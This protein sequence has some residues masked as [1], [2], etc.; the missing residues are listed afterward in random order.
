MKLAHIASAILVWSVFSV[1]PVSAQDAGTSQQQL[2]RLRADM[3]VMREDQRRLYSMLQENRQAMERLQR[4]M[5]EISRRLGDGGAA[6]SSEAA[7]RRDIEA[8]RRALR[9]ESEARQKAI[10]AVIDTLSRDIAALTVRQAGRDLPAAAADGRREW[11]GE[12][13]GEYTVVRGDTLS[14]IAQ[15]FGISTQR[16]RQANNLTGDLIREGQVLVIPK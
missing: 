14:A 8:L 10:D 15:A 4:Q 16:L 1:A 3:E 5:G 12:V 11:S 6:A 9:E 13:Q 2:A 7:L